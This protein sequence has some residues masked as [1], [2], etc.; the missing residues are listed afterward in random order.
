MK[1][2][3]ITLFTLLAVTAIS[4]PSSLAQDSTTLQA[5]LE[6]EL[7]ESRNTVLKDRPYRLDP[8]AIKQVTIVRVKPSTQRSETVP[9]WWS[10]KQAYDLAELLSLALSRYAGIKAK[11]SQSWE[12]NLLDQEKSLSNKQTP[13]KA[14]ETSNPLGNPIID[15]QMDILSYNFQHMPIKRR[16]IGL[17]FV[18][19]TVK[20]CS[21]ETHLKT[22]VSI[23]RPLANKAQ[24]ESTSPTAINDVGMQLPITRLINSSTGGASLNFNFLVGGAG[25][26]NFVPPDKPL[27]KIILEGTVD[28]AE[29]I[30]CLITDQKDCLKYYE[31]RPH[32]NPSRLSE[33][34]K[35]RVQSC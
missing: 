33:K 6:K 26:G 34:D 18:A 9:E 35:R 14:A 2:F 29:A 21:T 10:D 13:A 30:Y 28:A 3:S 20:H 22:A 19:M 25:G 31:Q 27:K 5:T 24:K 15:T 12:Q 11:P 7:S 32:P 17:G 16:G 23:E 1:P 4:P 8:Y